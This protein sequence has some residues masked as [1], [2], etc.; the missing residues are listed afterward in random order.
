MWEK[1]NI[2]SSFPFSVTNCTISSPSCSSFI[3]TPFSDTSLPLHPF[4]L[5]SLTFF[6]THT[7][8]RLPSSLKGGS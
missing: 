3:S 1:D 7:S 6:T 8:F 4:S 2:T 5:F